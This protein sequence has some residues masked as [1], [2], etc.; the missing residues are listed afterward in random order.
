MSKDQYM[1]P[2]KSQS[3][4]DDL[5]PDERDP[6]KP[7]FSDIKVLANELTKDGKVNKWRLPLPTM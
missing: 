2:V 7:T 5:N 4:N 1:N 6:T 3:M